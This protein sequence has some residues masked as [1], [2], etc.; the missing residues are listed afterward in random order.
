MKI[1]WP[2]KC[3]DGDWEAW[4]QEFDEIC[5]CNGVNDDID[6]LAALSTLLNGRAK[7]ALLIHRQRTSNYSYRDVCSALHEE[8]SKEHDRQNALHCFFAAQYAESEDPMVH[9]AYL[10][11][12]LHLGL[13]EANAATRKR[14]IRDRFIQGLPPAIKEKVQFAVLCGI[15]EMDDLVSLVQQLVNKRNEGNQQQCVQKL[16]DENEVTIN[17]L[18]CGS[19]KQE[20]AERTGGVDYC[21]S[22]AKFNGHGVPRITVVIDG[23]PQTAIIDTGAGVSILGTKIGREVKP[24]ALRV[25]AVGGAPLRVQGTVSVKIQIGESVLTHSMLV[26]DNVDETIIGIDLLR[27]LQAQIDLKGSNVRITN[28]DWKVSVDGDIR[29][30][31]VGA[32][33]VKEL[34]ECALPSVKQCVQEF[35]DLFSSSGDDY[36]LCTWLEHTIE[37]QPG[38]CCKRVQRRVPQKLLPELQR[39]IAEM[40]EKGIIQKTRSPYS[41]PVVLT[42]KADGSYR[43]C[44]DFRELNRITVKDAFPMPTADEIFS[45]LYQAKVIS[46]IDLRSGYWQLPM[47]VQDR[48]KTAFCINGQQYEFLRMPF[49]LC[50]APATFRRLLLQILE[51]L[52]GVMVYG[53]D[54][55]VYATTETEHTIRLKR[56]FERIRQA[57]LKLS[58]KKC[59]LARQTIVC[60]GHVVGN[61]QLRPLPEKLESIKNYPAPKSKRQLRSFLGLVGYDSKFVP[62]FAEKASPLFQLLQKDR[63]FEWT[64]EL[65]R[66]FNSLKEAVSASPKCLTI[67]RP[68][69]RFLVSVDA[70]DIGIGAVLSQPSGIVEYASRVLTPAERKY[71]TT[72]KECLAMVWALEKWR[73]YLIADNFTVKSDH[74][75]LVWLMTAK[76]PRGRLSR[77]ALRLQEFNFTVEHISGEQNSIPDALSR[78]CREID[79][80]EEVIPVSGVDVLQQGLREHQAADALCQG[81]IQHLRRGSR[82]EA[83]SPEMRELLRVWKKLRVKNDMLVAEVLVGS[84]RKLSHLPYVPRNNR[85]SVLQMAH[86]EVHIG[87]DR[88]LDL[89][90]RRMFWPQLRRDVYDF[91]RTC[92]ECQ[93]YKY[94]PVPKPPMQSI[95]AESPASEWGVDVFGPL[96]VSRRGNRYLVVM[97]DHF[98]RWVD[99]IPTAD[100]TADTVARVVVENIVA[101]FGVP[102]R[103]I[104]DQGPCFESRKFQEMLQYW[105]IQ[106]ARTSPYHPQANG[107]T[108]R[109][110]RTLKDW[111]GKHN[112][113]WEEKLPEVLFH[114]RTTKHASTKVTPFELVYGREGRTRLDVYASNENPKILSRNERKSIQLAATNNTKQIHRRNK[115]R[116]DRENR[117]ENWSGFKCGDLV[118]VKDHTRPEVT[119]AGASKFKK[120]WNG[121]FVVLEAKGTSF[122]INQGTRGRWVNGGDLS[123]WFVRREPFEGGE[124][125]AVRPGDRVQPSGFNR[126]SRMATRS[127]HGSRSN[128]IGQQQSKPA[129]RPDQRSG[130]STNGVRSCHGSW[131]NRIGQQQSQ[132]ASR[133][134]QRSTTGTKR[135]SLRSHEVARQTHRHTQ[136]ERNR[137]QRRRTLRR[138]TINR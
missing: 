44:V 94:T 62:G 100:Q 128:R 4:L 82:P 43:F 103:L 17:Y 135:V 18:S 20:Q 78:P 86:D 41:S 123:H 87:C 113:D 2:T 30:S 23:Q 95:T 15:Q 115:K 91:V 124:S 72:E 67:P 32:V 117:T 7:A 47:A 74:K 130:P 11:R 35:S 8:F 16:P 37:L 77:W 83:N 28:Q 106:R 49:G 109:F 51:G 53:D 120:K 56:L 116:Y 57:G 134:D 40:L 61:G 65:E 46:L 93:S 73:H 9:Y 105:G 110:N 25:Q 88:V 42:R 70:S 36:G 6:R 13:P 75:P 80:P 129:N 26:V 60:L 3:A 107:V 38:S 45:Q 71:S 96:P 66:S 69:E 55:V 122:K 125:V 119:G 10:L 84:T 14:L 81:V 31:P 137:T 27:R 12:K 76:D 64:N 1:N 102:T 98:T 108:E 52:E 92:P 132:L 112:V 99:A 79:L 114:Y 133:P 126:A 111:I 54:I 48:K 127:C 50:N 59:Q 63:K 136:R 21:Y 90:S 39:Q 121:P 138:R 131:P 29:K 68:D 33:E 97:V 19:T 104:T 24:C 5:E 22:L 89:L 101:R 118:R 58:S 85:T 34:P